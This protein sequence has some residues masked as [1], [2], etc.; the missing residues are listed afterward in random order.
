V[1]I[2]SEGLVAVIRVVAIALCAY[3]L[4]AFPTGYLIGRLRGL[5]IRRFGSGK[6]GGTNVGRTLGTV[7]GLVTGITDLLKGTAAVLVA[8]QIGGPPPAQALAAFLVILGHNFNPTLG[9]KGGAGVATMVG[10]L[11]ALWP[12]PLAVALPV[13]GAV[14]LTTRYV[15]L[16]SLSLCA[17]L[18]ISGLLGFLMHWTPVWVFGELCAAAALV[19]YAHRSNIQRLLAGTERRMGGKSPR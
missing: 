16:G 15:S 10:G 4:G 9:W 8:R 11:L 17:V 18:A 3:A 13:G 6:T 2:G 7:P 19:V 1:D 14:L 5:D 12:T